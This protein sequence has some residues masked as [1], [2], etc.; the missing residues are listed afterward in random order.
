MC[1]FLATETKAFLDRVRRHDTRALVVIAMI[2][3]TGWMPAASAC[4]PQNDEGA[5]PLPSADSEPDAEGEDDAA[6]PRVVVEKG[7]NLFGELIEESPESSA[8]ASKLFLQRRRKRV[9]AMVERVLET[10]ARY[11]SI[12]SDLQRSSEE[13]Q[14]LQLEQLQL[15]VE[16][17]AIAAAVLE[18]EFRVAELRAGGVLRFPNNSPSLIRFRELTVELGTHYAT[19]KRMQ[20]RQQV[21]PTEIARSQKSIVNL[22]RDEAGAT[23]DAIDLL[24]SV[25]EVVGPFVWLPFEEAE[26][27][28]DLC[29]VTLDQ[30]PRLHL[31]RL[32]EGYAR[33]HM[34]QLHAAQEKFTEVLQWTSGS[35]SPLDRGL[36]AISLLGRGWVATENGD[37]QLAGKDL[38]AARRLAPKDY[39]IAVALAYL[40]ENRERHGL[41]FEQY[42]SAARLEPSLPHAYRMA[43]MLVL[44]SGCRPASMACDLA[45]AACQQDEQDDWR[46]YLALALAYRAVEKHEESA[47]SLSRAREAADEESQKQIDRAVELAPPE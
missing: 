44:G 20:A 43:A 29:E 39:H 17:E 21:V 5:K 1:R 9:A 10:S 3:A 15:P 46:N 45:I 7:T 30:Y 37:F 24:V 14:S 11:N 26:A 38:A 19:I 28:A 36:Q 6:T 41:A 2:L 8:T 27:I 31:V 25:R 18:K 33:M 4:E 40:A 47:V 42:R 34:G 13:L 16:L 23:Q 22:R 35:R 12:T 32:V